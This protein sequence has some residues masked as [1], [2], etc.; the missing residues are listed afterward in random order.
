[1]AVVAAGGGGKNLSAEQSSERPIGG[2]QP[3]KIDWPATSIAAAADDDDGADWDNNLQ[4][5]RAAAAAEEGKGDVAYNGLSGTCSSAGRLKRWR[6]EESVES[7]RNWKPKLTA[8]EQPQEWVE[9]S[10]RCCNWMGG[11]DRIS[12]LNFVAIEHTNLSISQHKHW[13]RRKER[14]F[15]EIFL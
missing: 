9:E 1:V 13:W 15:H 10:V 2:K 3:A 6:L 8:V 12:S 5:E 11:G 14:E 4:Q 7:F